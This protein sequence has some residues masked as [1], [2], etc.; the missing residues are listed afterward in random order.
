MSKDLDSNNNL[1]DT[2]TGLQNDWP[3]SKNDA[4]LIKKAAGLSNGS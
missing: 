4:K 3:L 2:W 1:A